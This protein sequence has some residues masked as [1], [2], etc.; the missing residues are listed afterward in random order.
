MDLKTRYQEFIGILK[1]AVKEITG[2]KKKSKKRRKGTIKTNN[3][4]KSGIKS[5]TNRDKKSSKLLKKIKHYI[6][7]D[8]TPSA[9]L[10]QGQ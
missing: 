10:S 6:V 2:K 1:K 8:V 7:C 3:N 5:E 4:L 9:P